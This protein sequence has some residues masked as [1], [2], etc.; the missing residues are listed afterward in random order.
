M[1]THSTHST[2]SQRWRRLRTAPPAEVRLG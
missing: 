1:H 2:H